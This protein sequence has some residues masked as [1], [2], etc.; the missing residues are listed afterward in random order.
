MTPP[1]KNS[2]IIG[3]YDRIA[4]A[5]PLDIVISGRYASSA[6]GYVRRLGFFL[7]EVMELGPQDR[8]LDAGCSVGLYHPILAAK[9]RQ[10][11]GVDASPHS[12]DRARKRYAKLANVEYRVANL[13]ELDARDFP[14]GFDKILCYSVVHFLDGREDLQALLANLA[15]M[16]RERQGLI[17]LGEVRDRELYHGF[18]AK[19]ET[20]NWPSV[21]DWKFRMLRAVQNWFLP[22]KGLSPGVAPTLFT[23]GEIRGAVCKLGGT[24]ERI[25]QASWHPFYNTCVDYRLRF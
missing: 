19:R 24:C 2:L 13:L 15:G 6:F 4:A 5:S 1:S 20:Q 21:R 10:L 3:N 16:L 14:T 8:V 25:E 18:Q 9:V 17:Y 12:I 22:K 11:V 23:E 7:A